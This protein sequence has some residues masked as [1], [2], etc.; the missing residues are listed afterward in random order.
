VPDIILAVLNWSAPVDEVAQARELF[1]REAISLVAENVMSGLGARVDKLNLL[2]ADHKRSPALCCP[3]P[4][5]TQT[6]A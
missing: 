5:T 2:S 4:E 6:E 3:H 1:G